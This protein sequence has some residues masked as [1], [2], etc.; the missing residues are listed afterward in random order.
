MRA[1]V[2]AARNDVPGSSVRRS[3]H[4]SST[5]SLSAGP[6]SAAAAARHT[7]IQSTKA[8]SSVALADSRARSYAASADENSPF[9][10][11]ASA[12]RRAASAAALNVS[13]ASAI[14]VIAVVRPRLVRLPLLEGDELALF[15]ARLVGEGSPVFE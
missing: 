13:G 11:S 12:S 5:S 9:S 7:N 1:A 6:S 4:F 3:T 14:S 8:G 15:A 2:Y 10:S